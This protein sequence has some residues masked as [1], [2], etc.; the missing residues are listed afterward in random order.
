MVAP[1]SQKVS[2]S[3]EAAVKSG[4]A[5]EHL[6]CRLSGS[7]KR[8]PELEWGVHEQ[9]E[10]ALEWEAACNPEE[11]KVRSRNLGYACCWEGRVKAEDGELVVLSHW[12]ETGAGSKG[13]AS[14][15]TLL[16]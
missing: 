3:V 6:L 12:G 1:C 4:L 5:Q 14:G 11:A 16:L 13:K 8:V 2:S 7:G 15:G 10:S 9:T